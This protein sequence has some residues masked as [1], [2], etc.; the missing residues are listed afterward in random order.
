MPLTLPAFAQYQGVLPPLRGLWNAA[1]AEGDRFVNAEIDWGT[2]GGSPAYTCVQ[3]QLSGNSPVAFS[4]I[5]ALSVDNSR[6]GADVD[7]VF[8][9]SGFVLTVPAHAQL[10]A[11]V[12][13]NALMFYANAPGAVATDTTIL[14]ILNSLP[15][16]VALLPSSEQQQSFA[17]A[18]SLT[19][20]SSTQLIANTVTGTLNA[21]QMSFSGIPATATGISTVAL[22][23][24]AGS[25][26]WAAFVSAP[27]PGPVSLS[28]LEKR[29]VHGLSLVVSSATL[30]AGAIVPNVYYTVP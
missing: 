13:T 7:F 10:V 28:G 20:N 22:V 2:L 29:F 19:S 11:P 24:G 6:C 12:F 25:T 27:Q 3:F 5:V 23:D 9:D 8:P 4:Q 21:I 17:T 18:I 14:Q 16:P 26:L 15:P 1:P 30:S